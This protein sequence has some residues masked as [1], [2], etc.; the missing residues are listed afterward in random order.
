MEGQIVGG[1][2]VRNGE[3]P[4]VA[5]LLNKRAG[6]S[7]YRQ[8]F[9]GGTLIDRN[10][11]LTAA[12]CV[13]GTRVSHLRV[14]V[15]RTALNSK[16]GVIRNVTGV[17]VHPKYSDRSSKHDAA[18]LKIKGSVN[19]VEPIEISS[20]SQNFLEKKGTRA[21]VAGWGNTIAQPVGGSNRSNFSNRMQKAHLPIRTDRYGRSIYKSAYIPRLMIAAG[22]KGKDTCQGDSGGPLFKKTGGEY[23]QIGIT[24]FGAGCGAPG[25]PGVYTEVN[26]PSVRSFII[27]ASRR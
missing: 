11:I 4:F 8:Q 18:V 25:H 9:C 19:N 22:R 12:H 2:A 17:F 3:Y 1:A 15:G 16:Q 13:K 20:K 14:T 26:S 7:P 27:K 5:A 24:S 23:Y 6:S 21:T 10:S